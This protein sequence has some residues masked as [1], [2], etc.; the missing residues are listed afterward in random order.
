MTTLRFVEQENNIFVRLLGLAQYGLKMSHC[1]AVTADG[2]YIG[3]HLLGGVQE[4]QPGY[5]AGFK[6]ETFVL[7]KTTPEQH[8]KFLAFLRS[9]LHEPYDPI[10][11][12][13]FWGPFSSKNWQ[14]PRAWTCSEFIAEGLIACGWL[15]RNAK[16]PSI[17]LAPRD[18][19][20]LTSTLEA[21]A[22]G[23]TDG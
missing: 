9:H 7:L 5:D 18:L 17:R 19:Y 8:A 16:V 21:M 22:S 12:V 13:Y 10:S 14:D 4:L 2:T 20:Y 15:P 1:D 11:V 3:A 23:G 6:Q